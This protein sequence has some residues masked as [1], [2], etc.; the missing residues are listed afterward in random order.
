MESMADVVSRRGADVARK[1]WGQAAP[2]VVTHPRRQLAPFFM[3]AP[4]AVTITAFWTGGAIS[5]A[6]QT[7]FLVG[8]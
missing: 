4:V 3:A 5:V 2:P 1:L 7:R 8:T 6:S